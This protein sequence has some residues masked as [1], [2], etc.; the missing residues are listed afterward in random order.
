MLRGSDREGSLA[1][2][3][4][5]YRQMTASSASADF[6]SIWAA[7]RPFFH[8]DRVGLLRLLALDRL[9]LEEA[10]HRHDGAYGRDV[11]RILDFAAKVKPERRRTGARRRVG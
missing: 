7:A 11:Q 6:H 5:L 9:L 1:T 3:A 10:V 4:A 8:G 2:A